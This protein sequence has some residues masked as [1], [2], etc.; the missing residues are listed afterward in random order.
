MIEQNYERFWVSLD[1]RGK[2]RLE[3]IAAIYGIQLDKR[4]GRQR[5]IERL[6]EDG[7]RKAQFD[8]AVGG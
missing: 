1:K 7:Y 6:L 3:A 2:E 5:V 8:V 4:G